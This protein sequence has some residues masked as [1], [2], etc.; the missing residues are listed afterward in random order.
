MED[1]EKFDWYVFDSK[2]KFNRRKNMS[3]EC[4]EERG[5]LKMCSYVHIVWY[6]P[7]KGFVEFS[8]CEYNVFDQTP[9]MSDM[10]FVSVIVFSC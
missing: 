9:T 10:Y 5:I 1:H 6:L 2:D 3:C 7:N 4:V 8:H